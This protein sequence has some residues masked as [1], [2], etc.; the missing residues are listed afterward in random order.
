MDSSHSRPDTYQ[1]GPFKIKGKENIVATAE[2]EVVILPKVM[3]LLLYLCR[4]SQQVVT[5]DEIIAEVWPREIVGDNAIYN[6]VGQLRKALGDKAS[7]PT[8]VQTVSKVGYR[9][10]VSAEPISS[11]SGQPA[12]K[13]R[14]AEQVKKVQDGSGA[15]WALPLMFLA[16]VFGVVM[17]WFAKET[18]PVPSPESQRQLKLAYYQLYRGDSDGVD[19]GIDT[20]QQLAASEPRWSVP[21]IELAYGFIRK[22]RLDPDNDDFWLTK[23]RTIGKEDNLGESGRRLTAVVKAMADQRLE[24]NS[25]DALFAD[26]DILVS[27]RLAYSDVLFKLGKIDQASEQVQLALDDC[28]DCPYAYRKFA[29]TQ[30]VQG[31]I[32]QGF[33]SFLHYRMLINRSSQNPADNAGYV[34]LTKDSLREMADWHF[35]TPTPPDLLSHQRNALALFYLSLGQIE[36]AE[37]TL[38]TKP[39]TSTQFFDL[40]T[41]AALAGARGDF[42]ASYTLLNKRQTSYPDNERFKLSVVYALWQLSRYEEAMRVFQRFQILA[43]PASFPASLPHSMPFSTWSLYG[44]LLM[45]TGDDANGAKILNALEQRLRAGLVPGSHKADIRLAQVLALQGN[46][47]DALDE[48]R[49]AVEQGWVSDFNQNWWYLQDSPYFRALR[50]DEKF[51][52]IVALY[53]DSIAAEFA[54]ANRPE[55]AAKTPPAY[56]N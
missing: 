25:L 1:L 9:L 54:Q 43:L 22:S 32:E 10:L 42:E 51:K 11:A 34:P 7:N 16:G 12:E 27:A 2:G 33:D 52:E 18:P 44:A 26:E 31:K 37:G 13:N 4:H 3:T 49:L 40:Y 36:L 50:A 39:E 55:S 24:P 28:P 21:K 6:L 46:D 17:A 45:Q 35:K 20:L 15:K 23:A 38:R 56:R 5:F 41:H 47:R 48:L 14:P 30:M 29:T 19:Q 8:Y 53:H